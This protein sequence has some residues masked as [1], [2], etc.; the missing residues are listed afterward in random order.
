MANPPVDTASASMP[1]PHQETES[2]QGTESEQETE[3]ERDTESKEETESGPAPEATPGADATKRDSDGADG[4]QDA[5]SIKTTTAN[6]FPE[7]RPH[8]LEPEPESTQRK[9][10]LDINEPWYVQNSGCLFPFFG[11]SH[12]SH[13][14]P[15]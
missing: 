10:G 3:S 5:A 11:P 14:S 12:Y 1:G 13:I 2:E 6:L 15:G 7:Y 8:G 4:S 9:L